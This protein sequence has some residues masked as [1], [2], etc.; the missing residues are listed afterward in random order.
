MCCHSVSQLQRLTKLI[1]ENVL[2]SLKIFNFKGDSDPPIVE[3]EYDDD[4]TQD[5]ILVEGDIFVKSDNDDGILDSIM[6]TDPDR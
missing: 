4:D 3:Y 2:F 5:T 6:T 1:V